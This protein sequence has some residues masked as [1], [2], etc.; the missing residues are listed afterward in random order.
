MLSLQ[1]AGLRDLAIWADPRWLMCLGS[2]CLSLSTERENSPSGKVRGLKSVHFAC[3]FA[4]LFSSLLILIFAEQAISQSE[5]LSW[6]LRAGSWELGSAGLGWAGLSFLLEEQLPSPQ[7]TRLTPTSNHL[8]TP[9]LFFSIKPWDTMHTHPHTHAQAHTN[10]REGGTE[11]WDNTQTTYS[12][13][14][15]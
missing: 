13:V 11:G 15:I 9:P 2:L 5:G 7:N 6:E 14:D 12:F 8:H 10:T 4:K 1:I 3:E